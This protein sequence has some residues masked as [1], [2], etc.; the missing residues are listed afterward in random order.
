[1]MHLLETINK[2]FSNQTSK[3][4][5]KALIITITQ[6]V[7]HV[8]GAKSLFSDIT[9]IYLL[10]CFACALCWPDKTSETLSVPTCLR[11]DISACLKILR[12]KLIRML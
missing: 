1:M 2:N 8:Y 6:V 4:G 5:S 9:I 11:K 12:L 10:S 7:S 3:G